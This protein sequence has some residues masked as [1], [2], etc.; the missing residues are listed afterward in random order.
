MVYTSRFSENISAA[1]QT[2]PPIKHSPEV[3]IFSTLP[4]INSARP[5]PDNAAITILKLIILFT[6]DLLAGFH[7]PF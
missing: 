7:R 5:A 1:K 2:A 3:N 4:T 6:L